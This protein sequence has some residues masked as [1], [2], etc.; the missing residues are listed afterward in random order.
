MILRYWRPTLVEEDNIMLAVNNIYVSYGRIN[1][2]RGVSIVVREGEAVC[3][4]G[5]NGAGKS[6]LLAAILGVQQPNSG[7]IEFLGKDIT[8]SST[9]S[10]VASGIAAS[11]EDRGILPFMSVKEIL[12]LGAYHVKGDKT[13]YMERALAH[14]PILEER[15]NQLAGTLS[16]GEQQMLDIAR[17]LMSEPRLMILDEPSLGLAPILVE[18]LFDIFRDLKKEGYTILLAEQNARMALESADRAYILETGKVTLEGDSKE[19]ANDP[20][21]QRAYLGITD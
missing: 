9:D 10:I 13:K 5:S 8:H 3:L 15:K 20:R 14:F 16:G 11:P 18:A 19:L 4:I 17:V 1:A 6:T 2:L 7:T 12:M 21:V